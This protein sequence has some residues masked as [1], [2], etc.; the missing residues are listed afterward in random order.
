MA[1]QQIVM[2]SLKHFAI[3]A[4]KYTPGSYCNVVL[5]ATQSTNMVAQCSRS[6]PGFAAM[7]LA[8]EYICSM[9][10][11]YVRQMSLAIQRST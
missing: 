3:G 10:Q 7:N 6:H 1:S 5:T 8:P 9:V 4:K 2:R 11:T